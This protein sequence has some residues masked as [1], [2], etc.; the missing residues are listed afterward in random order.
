MESVVNMPD[1]NPAL[2]QVDQTIKE[3]KNTKQPPQKNKQK[4]TEQ[5]HFS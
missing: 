1:K 2:I 3:K 4:K 5:D